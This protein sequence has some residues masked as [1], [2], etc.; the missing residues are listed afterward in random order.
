MWRSIRGPR[1]PSARGR[2]VTPVLA[3]LSGDAQR[4]AV[5]RSWNSVRKP[6]TS[7]N[8]PVAKRFHEHPRL[9]ETIVM[10]YDGSRAL[11]PRRS[12]LKPDFPPPDRPYWRTREAG[13]L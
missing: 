5:T 12:Y 9:T 1:P 8:G 6:L 10:S 4:Q 7:D 13:E 11:E 3:R 2:P